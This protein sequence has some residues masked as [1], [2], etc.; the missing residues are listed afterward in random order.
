MCGI[1][2]LHKL[3]YAALRCAKNTD[4]KKID[5]KR[6]VEDDEE[7]L[8]VALWS[9][10]TGARSRTIVQRSQAVHREHAETWFQARYS[11]LNRG[12]G[13]TRSRCFFLSR[14]SA[15]RTR[16]RTKNSS[17]SVGKPTEILNKASAGNDMRGPVS[18]EALETA[19]TKRRFSA[20]A[21]SVHQFS[22]VW[23]WMGY[24]AHCCEREVV[25]SRLSTSDSLR[26]CGHMLC[27]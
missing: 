24:A 19:A 1:R 7:S 18:A 11:C 13:T 10:T 17:L 23:H 15:G 6:T 12:L 5:D 22:D 26:R 25:G 4:V 21:L 27:A 16:L 20:T 3:C 8:N 2:I 9:K 14:T